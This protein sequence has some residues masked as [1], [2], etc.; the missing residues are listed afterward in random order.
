[1]ARR[2]FDRISV[3][4]QLPDEQAFFSRVLSISVGRVRVG[5]ERAATN[6]DNLEDRMS[7]IVIYLSV[8]LDGVMQAPARPDEDTRGGFA[9]GGWAVPFSDPELGR[10]AGENMARSGSLLLGRRTYQDFYAVWPKRRDNPYT[11]VLNNTQKYVASTTLKQLEWSNSTLLAGDAMQAV[12]RLREA[13]GKDT[14]VLGSGELTR[15]LMRHGLV[16]RYVLSIYP[17]VLGS[18]RRLFPD[19]G[20]LAKLRLTNTQTTTAGVVIATYASRSA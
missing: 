15:T 20:T 17:L 6:A 16:D 3:R 5:A 2:I 11:E 7:D 13:P 4:A 1:V 14:V 12:A 18:G 19:D 10:V 8:T 9:H